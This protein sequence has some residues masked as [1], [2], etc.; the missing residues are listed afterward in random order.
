MRE[1]VSAPVDSEPI[2]P[3]APVQPF[4]AVQALAPVVDQASV[5]EAPKAIVPGVA[6]SVTAG[7]AGRTVTVTDCVA[8]PPGPEHASA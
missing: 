4:E 3:R 5:A 8:E 2:V 6:V 1:A 7:G